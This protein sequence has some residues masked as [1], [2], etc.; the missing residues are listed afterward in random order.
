MNVVA[1]RT[2]IKIDYCPKL[3]KFKSDNFEY[4]DEQVRI[5]CEGIIY[6]SDDLMSEYNTDSLSDVIKM[7][8][9]SKGI[10][11]IPNIL[12]GMYVVAVE[13]KTSNKTFIINDLLSKAPL[14]YFNDE[15]MIASTSFFDEVKLVKDNNCN[16]NINEK[17][18]QKVLE[19]GF[20]EYD[21]TYFTQ[22]KFLEF[23]QYICICDGKAEIENYEYIEKTDVNPADEDKFCEKLYEYFDNS[24]RQAVLKNERQGY[25]NIF[26]LSGG[27]DCRCTFLA[28][29]KYVKNKSISFSYGNYR[30][31]DLEIGAQ[32]ASDYNLDHFSYTTNPK[33]LMDRD[34]VIAVNEGQMS[35][36]GTTGLRRT[37]T[38]LDTENSGLIYTGLSGGE[39]FGD[40]C[41]LEGSLEENRISRIQDVRACLNFHFSSRDKIEVFSPYLDEDFF[42]LMTKTEAKRLR[43]KSFYYKWYCMYFNDEHKINACEAAPKPKYANSFFG[44]IM[45]L[46]RVA[47]KRLK[48][49]SR[50]DMNPIE[51]WIKS[52]NE[53]KEYID[54]TFSKDILI[55]ENKYSDYAGVLRERFAK[56]S[57]PLKL[58]VL[59]V[60]KVLIS[61][62]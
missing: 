40:A 43:R 6:N 7:V 60:C 44:N 29:K 42:M 48:L 54:N 21:N 19:R 5:V 38:N 17:G 30:C 31:K 49:R 20:F 18:I 51:L 11:Y 16:L 58:K 13:D 47:K 56:V 37:I 41:T 61:C 55:V 53:L 22:I 28:C 10:I 23:V 45:M 12:H 33:Y 59:T 8:Y 14:Y 50:W 52:D 39:V 57:Y 24:C 36:E 2:T 32:I 9:F 1:D 34:E 27:L 62:E 46:K 25:K 4:E 3:V 15:K 35:Y 26:T